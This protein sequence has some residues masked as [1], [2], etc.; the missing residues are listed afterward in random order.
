MTSYKIMRLYFHGSPRTIKKNLTL[1]EAKAH[2]SD[3]ETSSRTCKKSV[4]KRRTLER[5]HW[6]DSYCEE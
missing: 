5:G 4:N 1:E 2:C 3:P 6:F